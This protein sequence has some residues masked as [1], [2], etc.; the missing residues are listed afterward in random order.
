MGPA[1]PLAHTRMA[2][3]LLNPA[4]AIAPCAKIAGTAPGIGIVIDIAQ[5]Y[6]PGDERGNI[7]LDGA[8]IRIF[9]QP[10]LPDLAHKI[11]FQPCTGGGKPRRI[12]QRQI[13]QSGLSQ[14]RFHPLRRPAFP[15]GILPVAMTG[16]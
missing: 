4:R 7:D 8:A 2:Q 13:A 9:S 6:Q 1:Q 12:M 3:A 15:P 5:F 11:A 16:E 14:R 10:A